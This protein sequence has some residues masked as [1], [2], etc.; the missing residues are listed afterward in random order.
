MVTGLTYNL[1]NPAPAQN[2]VDWHVD[3]GC[4]IRPE[5]VQLGAVGYFFQQITPDS[6]AAAFL[7]TNESRVAGIGPQ[8]GYLFPVGNLQG[9]LNLKGYWEFAA[10]NRASGWNTWLTFSLSPAPPAAASPPM[11]HK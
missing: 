1:L 8:I 7:G 6:G 4:A 5:A 2:G 3:W 10:D 9:Y 11:L